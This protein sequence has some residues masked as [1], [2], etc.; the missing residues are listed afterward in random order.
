MHAVAYSLILS[1]PSSAAGLH[2]TG[3]KTCLV[4]RG[5]GLLLLL[6]VT[7]TD[8]LIPASP[9]LLQCLC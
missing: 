5:G 4:C 2:L 6:L 1:E 7:W 9:G 3:G 8:E